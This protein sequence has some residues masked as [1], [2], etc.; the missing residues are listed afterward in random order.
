VRPTAGD[1]LIIE[2]VA[3]DRGCAL[4]CCV[5]LRCVALENTGTRTTLTV[6]SATS[7]SAG[8]TTKFGGAY[9]KESHVILFFFCF[10]LARSCSRLVTK[11][12]HPRSLKKITTTL[13]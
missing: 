12:C 10:V 5:A 3:E 2:T 11:V 9:K 4:L 13:R 8:V 6:A 7:T 1:K